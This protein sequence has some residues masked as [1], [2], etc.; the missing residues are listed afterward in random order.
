M[1][2]GKRKKKKEKRAKKRKKLEAQDER[3]AFQKKLKEMGVMCGT[4]LATILCGKKD[5]KIV[6]VTHKMLVA[7]EVVHDIE[8][9]DVAY[10]T[11]V[12][13][14]YMHREMRWTADDAPVDD[15]GALIHVYQYEFSTEEEALA[16]FQEHFLTGRIIMYARDGGATQSGP[17]ENTDEDTDNDDR[18][19]V[20][21]PC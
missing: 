6:P 16:R 14:K 10:G 19:D 12:N 9:Y 5:G 4:P 2:N 13:A 7:K 11:I 8:N 20:I 17:E 1:N 21:V 15:P 3:R 18:G